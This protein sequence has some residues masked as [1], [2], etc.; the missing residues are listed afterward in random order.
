VDIPRILVYSVNLHLL[1]LGETSLLLAAT[2]GAAFAGAFLGNRLVKKVTLHFI[3][4]L[5]ALMLLGI[6]VALAAGII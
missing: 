1:R 6:A 3:R 4:I 5:V 2:V